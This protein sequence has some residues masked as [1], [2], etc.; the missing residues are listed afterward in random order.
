MLLP[1][2][3]LY[4]RRCKTFIGWLEAMEAKLVSRKLIQDAIEKG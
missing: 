3:V 1:S 2:E 4:C